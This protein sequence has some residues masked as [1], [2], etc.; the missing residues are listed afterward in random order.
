MT[1]QNSLLEQVEQRLILFSSL[2]SNLE[3]SSL[4]PKIGDDVQLIG[5]DVTNDGRV[6]VFSNL[7]KLISEFFGNFSEFV[8]IL[9][10]DHIG[11][12]LFP[13]ANLRANNIWTSALLNDA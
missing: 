6:D 8:L 11:K 9:I 13:V 4:L 2:F 7:E 3:E 1:H 12:S 10:S 5:K